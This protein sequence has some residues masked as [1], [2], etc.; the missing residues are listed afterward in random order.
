MCVFLRWRLGLVYTQKFGTIP[1]IS[2]SLLFC[3]GESEMERER[4][5]KRWEKEHR[6][7]QTV[8]WEN[9]PANTANRVEIQSQFSQKR[10]MI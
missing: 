7:R 8:W 2:G 9:T 10:S 4:V 6:G 3:E 1:T 5:R